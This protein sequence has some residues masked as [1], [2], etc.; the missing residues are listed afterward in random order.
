MRYGPNQYF[1]TIDVFS[2]EKMEVLR[3]SGSVQY[4]SDALGGTIQA[5]TYDLE[6]TGKPQWGSEILARA[7]THNMEQSVRTGLNHN[8]KNISF[9]TGVT[10]RKFGDIRG[11][12]TTGVQSPTGYRELD[13]DLKAG[14]KLSSKALL[15]LAYQDVSQSDVPVYHKVVLEDYV[16]NETDPQKRKLAYLRLNREINSGILKSATMTASWQ[17]TVENRAMQKNNSDILRIENDRVRSLGFSTEAAFTNKKAWSGSIGVEAYNDY[18]NS[19]R[20]DTDITTEAVT[21]KRGLYPDGST[22]NSLAAFTVNTFDFEKWILSAGARFNA[23]IIKVDDETLGET[24]LT[25]SALVGNI[26]ILRKLNKISNLFV[27]LNSG[28]R[29][30]NIDDLGTLGIV[31]FRYETPDFNLKPE[32]SLQYQAGYKYQTRKLRGELYV[33]RNELYN[34]I[35]RNRVED[36]FVEGYPL[37]RKENSDR[38]YIL[39]TETSWD[40]NPDPSWNFHGDITWTYGQNITKNE[41]VRRIPPLFGRLA[42]EYRYKNLL[43]NVEC[44][45][46]SK[47][48]R[49]AQGDMDDNRIP[50][51]GTPGWSIFNINGSYNWRYLTVDLSVKNILNTDYRYHGSGVNGCGRSM[52]LTVAISM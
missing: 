5:F 21:E 42:S 11:G 41:P 29:A 22:M 24:R 28:F 32:S 46:A 30:P 3:G 10:W 51:G 13:Y 8:S 33:Y 45:V 50:E 17:H 14:I 4:G 49:L 36:Q 26:A 40:F 44:L 2:I 37:Y 35:V 7:A 9:R 38:A 12:D 43:L 16:I 52:F 25:P 19:S 15:T 31:D 39:G 47:Q 20:T 27:S 23:F 18:V 1:N 34:L 48:E 6:M